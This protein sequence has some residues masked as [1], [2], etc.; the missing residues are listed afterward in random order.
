MKL[1]VPTRGFET[2]RECPECGQSEPVQRIGETARKSTGLVTGEHFECRR[3]YDG[4]GH[5][6]QV[7]T[8]GEGIYQ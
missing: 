2:D 3:K 1:G 6:W 7:D 8:Y 4:C 5:T